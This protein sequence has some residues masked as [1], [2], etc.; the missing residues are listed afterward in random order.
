[1]T[2]SEFN[3][4]ILDQQTAFAV[5]TDQVRAV[6]E[7]VLTEERI[8]SAEISVALLDDAAIQK[9]NRDFL[10]HD[11]PTDVISFRLNHDARESEH[12]PRFHSELSSGQT[13]DPMGHVEAELIISTETALREANGH[14]WSA[15]NELLLYVVHGT[16]HLCGYDDLSDDA[17][18]IMR[19]RE[20][21]FLARWQ[22]V[23]SGL[24][25]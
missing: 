13:S 14:G 2:T 8:P 16:L 9:V 11:F 20:R 12:G 24:E 15:A 19:D 4:D 3:I 17:R 5:D 7:H 23:P 6:I 21:K 22:L 10:G 1:M 18:P 25:A